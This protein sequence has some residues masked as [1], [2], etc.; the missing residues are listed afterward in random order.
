MA[1]TPASNHPL[2]VFPV[3]DTVHVE[4]A[5]EKISQDI[6]SGLQIGRVENAR[7]FRLQ[8]AGTPVGGSTLFFNRFGTLT[9]LTAGQIEGTAVVAVGGQEPSVFQIDGES[10]EVSARSAAVVGPGRRVRISRPAS[11]GLIGLRVDLARLE[12]RYRELTGRTPPKVWDFDKRVDLSTGPGLRLRQTLDYAIQQLEG[13][14]ALL[15]VKSLR[16]NMD[17]LLL[18]CFLFIP[19]EHTADLVLVHRAWR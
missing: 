9:E 4:Q 5:E 2:A 6:T 11:S 8:M 19:G 3:F 18:G 1:S 16:L 15:S 12:R 7:D 10:V 17:D 14:P 13:D